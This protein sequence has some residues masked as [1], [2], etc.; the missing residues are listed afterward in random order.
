MKTEH[1]IIL[2][3]MLVP[4]LM[5][6]FATGNKINFLFN[7]FALFIFY[8]MSL[9]LY[10]CGTLIIRELRTR[11][12]LQWSVAFL[13]IAYGIFEEGL[14]T[15]AFFNP[16]WAGVAPFQNYGMYLGVQ[17]PWA[18]GVTFA[19]ATFSTLLA[20]V[21][22]DYLW[23]EYRN[24]P[25]LG[26]IGWLFAL[27][28]FLG[29]GIFGSLTMG[30]S[31]IGGDPFI[32]HPVLMPATIIVIA[33]LVVLAYLLKWSKLKSKAKVHSPF[34][35]G[36]VAFLMQAFYLLS[37]LFVP[38]VDAPTM[39]VIYAVVLLLAFF[40]MKRQI[41][42]VNATPRHI[43]ALAFGTIL[44]FVALLPLQLVQ[45]KV[46]MAGLLPIVLILAWL[47]R[48]NVLKRTPAA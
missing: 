21:M 43:T 35:F 28:G 2:F 13:L 34:Y 18:I 27:L 12:K 36:L 7:P 20:I 8:T 11:W 16:D 30:N 19:H 33:S 38:A 40:F 31:E 45:G 6:E 48:T 39:L 46:A 42:N 15:K 5:G 22:S 44:F 1:K 4:P 26:K 10:G 47:W 25:L 23:P 37:G 32:P 3:L 9:L 41:Y 14:M 29:I 24:K 17:W